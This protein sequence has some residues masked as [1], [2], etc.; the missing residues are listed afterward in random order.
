M[1]DTQHKRRYFTKAQIS[2]VLKQPRYFLNVKE[3]KESK[4]EAKCWAEKM[5]ACARR[6]DVTLE[7]MEIMEQ[8][9]RPAT[10]NLRICQKK[11]C[12]IAQLWLRRRCFTSEKQTSLLFSQLPQLWLRL[13][14][15]TLEKKIHFLFSR[16]EKFSYLCNLKSLCR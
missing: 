1:Q 13:N 4:C 5:R 3:I 8:A 2:R 7:D 14:Y 10:Y 11:F 15:G 6:F 16:F 12:H 9:V